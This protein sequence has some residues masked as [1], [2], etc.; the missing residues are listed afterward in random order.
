MKLDT[1]GTRHYL[2]Q[3]IT[4]LFNGYAAQATAIF[5]HDAAAVAGMLGTALEAADSYLDRLEK[6]FNTALE[7][8]GAELDKVL[9]TQIQDAFNWSS[10]APSLTTLQFRQAFSVEAT[11]YIRM[12][13]EV[14]WEKRGTFALSMN[15]T[16][17]VGAPSTTRALPQAAA[18]A[19]LLQQV[20]T[21][22]ALVEGTG[23]FFNR[24]TAA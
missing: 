20:T 24:A 22:A 4:R 23:T 19:N 14:R 2:S 10:Y 13:A 12:K 16:T 21:L 1:T 18:F 3:D 9:A 17:E 8:D 7:K 15:L 6:L 5:G 11:L